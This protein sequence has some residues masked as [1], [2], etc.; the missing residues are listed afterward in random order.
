M[1]GDSKAIDCPF[2]EGQ[3]CDKCAYFGD[4]WLEQRLD[5]RGNIERI[6]LVSIDNVTH[7]SFT[8]EEDYEYWK[9]NVPSALRK[10]INDKSKQD[11]GV[12]YVTPKREDCIP[13][14]ITPVADNNNNS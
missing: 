5:A 10:S 7:R 8:S 3:K 4:M 13:A 14:P 9:S 1:N 2:C 12:V 6:L 11:I